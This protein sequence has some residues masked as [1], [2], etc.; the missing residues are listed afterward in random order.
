VIAA[1]ISIALTCGCR[2]H[3]AIS[4]TTQP[5]AMQNSPAP[6]TAPATQP[7]AMSFIIID[8]KAYEF[9]AAKILFRNKNDQ[10]EAILFSDDPLAAI[11]DN[12]SGNSFYLEMTPQLAGD[13]GLSGAV[14]DYKAP[15]ADRSDSVSGIYLHGRKQHLQPF[16]VHVVFGGAESPVPI[17]IS[18]IFLLFD[19]N[20]DQMPGK[21]VTLSAEFI[22]AVKA[23]PH[24]K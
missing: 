11:A 3:Q 18:G 20:N 5:L 19:A 7:Q 1:M 15:S 2:R 4:P 22:A 21:F 9:P 16:D 8:Q 13:A 17:T 23:P 12:Y 6:A 10:M 14:W 24:T